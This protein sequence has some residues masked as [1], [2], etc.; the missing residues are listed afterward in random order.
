MHRT[1]ISLVFVLAASLL[2]GCQTTTRHPD[3]SVTTTTFGG[4]TRGGQAAL[5]SIASAGI[6]GVACKVGE[7]LVRTDL[8]CVDA[9]VAA[10]AVSAA[11]DI[12]DSAGSGS[13][14]ARGAYAPQQRGVSA[15]AQDWCRAI[16][17]QGN[18]VTVSCSMIH[19]RGQGLPPGL[20]PRVDQNGRQRYDNFRRPMADSCSGQGRE[21]VQP[22]MAQPALLNPRISA[23][24]TQQCWRT[25]PGVDF[26]DKK[27]AAEFAS[28]WPNGT[29]WEVQC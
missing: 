8:P 5:S 20:C 15:P 11:V 2:G 24:P 13:G 16:N 3:G 17:D 22:R 25:T 28:R 7:K 12:F 27:Q 4:G 23:Y 18:P 6:A 10:G 21:T 26:T 19:A 1:I 14:Q 29:Y 9:A